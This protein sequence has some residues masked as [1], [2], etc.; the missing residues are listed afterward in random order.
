MLYLQYLHK[1]CSSEPYY[2]LTIACRYVQTVYLQELN[3][4]EIN[5]FPVIVSV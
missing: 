2:N 3:V 1:L 4:D 5:T